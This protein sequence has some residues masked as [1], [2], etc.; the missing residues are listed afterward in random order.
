MFEYIIISLFV[1]EEIIPFYFQAQL[2]FVP[3]VNFD[4]FIYTDDR[5]ITLSVKT[6]LRERY[7]QS[8]LEADSMLSVHRNSLNYL[9]SLD[10]NAIN[11][12]NEK[13][14]KKEITSLE[15]CIDIFSEDFDRLID[16]IKSKHILKAPAVDIVKISQILIE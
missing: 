9:L 1:R 14:K 6:S 12:V 16:L 2:A 10:K 4:F 15:Q 11:T 13:I 3:N 5:P 7:K 8:V